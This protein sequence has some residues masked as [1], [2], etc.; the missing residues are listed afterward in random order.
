VHLVSFIKLLL[1]IASWLERWYFFY[2]FFFFLS[3]SFNP[4]CSLI[5]VFSGGTSFL[6]YLSRVLFVKERS[7][8]SKNKTRMANSNFKKVSWSWRT[9]NVIDE[10][11][12]RRFSTTSTDPGSGWRPHHDRE[13][14]KDSWDYILDRSFL[15]ACFESKRG[16]L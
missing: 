14:E 4:F 16:Y 8:C 12:F 10:I 9:N 15:W 13:V 6:F 1:S 5:F 7:Q 2:F 11:T 3:V